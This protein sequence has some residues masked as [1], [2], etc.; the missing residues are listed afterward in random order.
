MVGLGYLL[1]VVVSLSFLGYASLVDVREREVSDKVWLL[2]LPLCLALSLLDIYMGVFESLALIV[3]V[4]SALA[5]GLVLYYA[6]FYGGADAKALLLIAAAVPAFP[7]LSES[8]LSFVVGAVF[9]VPFFLIFFASTLLSAL[10]P[11]G[12]LALNLAALLR[13]SNPLRGIAEKSFLKRLLLLA[14]V[15]RISFERLRDDARY[16]L[17]ERRAESEAGVERS[18]LY[19]VR[20]RDDNRE[21]VE[22]AERHS[23]LYRD[24]VLASPTIPMIVFLALGTAVTLLIMA[25]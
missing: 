14:T 16:M 17:A 9:P 11:L 13:G 25:I 19:S 24:G 12:I 8:F 22:E 21:L 15:R 18:P 10:W 2:S 5:L 23:E 3:S 4:A 7:F 1:R 6:G 20:I